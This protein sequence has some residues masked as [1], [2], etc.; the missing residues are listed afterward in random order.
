METLH[1][2]A[3]KRWHD[4]SYIAGTREALHALRNAIDCAL[5]KNATATAESFCCDGEGYK[6][7]VIPVTEDQAYVM[8]VPYTDELAMAQKD[9]EQFGPWALMRKAGG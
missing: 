4:E 3:Q 2:Y 5:N 8:P 1:I 7:H 9:T 6:I